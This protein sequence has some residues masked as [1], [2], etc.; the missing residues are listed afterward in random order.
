MK[1]NYAVVYPGSLDEESTD[2]VN[3]N[4]TMEE[5]ERWRERVR[6]QVRRFGFAD[7][8]ADLVVDDIL[9]AW[10]QLDFD[11]DKA[12]GAKPETLLTGLTYNCCKAAMRA[13]ARSR[14]RETQ[15]Q[16]DVMAA[17]NVDPMRREQPL[18]ID[19]QYAL[20]LLADDERNVC[21]AIMDGLTQREI[22][23]HCG[24]NRH[25]IRQLIDNVRE[26]F[27]ALGIDGWLD[28]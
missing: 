13:L 14:V 2:S 4:K 9:E 24:L 20:A 21:L 6:K 3:Y 19:V 23:D 8:D 17:R 5:A 7:V 10:R 15:H 12:N 16:D 28:A 27:T 25:Q 18:K 26:R 1:T 11:P 22:A